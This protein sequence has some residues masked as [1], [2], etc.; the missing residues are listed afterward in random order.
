MQVQW[1]ST[2]QTIFGNKHDFYDS[3]YLGLSA[4]IDLPLMRVRVSKV[5]YM[6]VVKTIRFEINTLH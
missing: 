1:S 4:L 6:F 3:F 2:S 5:N